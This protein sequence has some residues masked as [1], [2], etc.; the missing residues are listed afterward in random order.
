MFGDNI[1]K[2]QTSQGYARNSKHIK[3]QYL[4]EQQRIPAKEPKNIMISKKPTGSLTK[5]PNG[6]NPSGMSST[7]A[8]AA[9]PLLPLANK[10]GQQGVGL[11]FQ[12]N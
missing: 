11:T 10:Q 3:N 12:Q 6:Y 5:H 9:V 7:N 8:S 2:N 4:P 1:P